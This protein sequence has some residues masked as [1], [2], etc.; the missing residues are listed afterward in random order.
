MEFIITIVLL[1]GSMIGIFIHITI[2]IENLITTT[3]I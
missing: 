3:L 1:S 2:R